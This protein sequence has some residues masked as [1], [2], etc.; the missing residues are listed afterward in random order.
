MAFQAHRARHRVFFDVRAVG[1]LPMGELRELH[2]AEASFSGISK[3]NAFAIPAGVSF[4]RIPRPFPLP[5][6]WIKGFFW[7]RLSEMIVSCK[8]RFES[9][10]GCGGNGSSMWTGQPSSSK[11]ARIRS[12]LIA[13]TLNCLT[14]T[15]PTRSSCRWRSHFGNGFVAV[16]VS[17]STADDGPRRR[18]SIACESL[19]EDR[20]AF[21]EPAREPLARH[22]RAPLR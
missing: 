4:Q 7:L 8:R 20:L 2:L 15:S 18:D 3:A 12:W 6:K 14:S 5:R 1:V 9:C 22:K 13:G 19:G 17:A 10:S 11:A 21:E 16:A